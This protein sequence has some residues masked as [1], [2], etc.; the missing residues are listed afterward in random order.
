MGNIRRERAKERKRERREN[1]KIPNAEAVIRFLST[2]TN[3]T[4]VTSNAKM[5][6]WLDPL[7]N[8]GFLVCQRWFRNDSCST[9]KCRLFHADDNDDNISISHLRC[10]TVVSDDTYH[11]Q[12][13]SVLPPR[14][15][16]DLVQVN[17][18]E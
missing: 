6:G 5:E 18:R 14:L 1:A 3:L 10:L 2:D 12:E 7:E 15:L 8:E 17:T 13:L 9:K 4:N 11:G 16:A